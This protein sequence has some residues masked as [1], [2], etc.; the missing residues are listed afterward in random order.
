MGSCGLGLKDARAQLPE[1]PVRLALE[2]ELELRTH[3][4]SHQQRHCLAGSHVWSIWQGALE[5][6]TRARQLSFSMAF[7]S[8]LPEL[9]L[10]RNVSQF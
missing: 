8:L 3:A 1:A 10:S 4:A 9:R 5:V 2:L 6:F 7:R